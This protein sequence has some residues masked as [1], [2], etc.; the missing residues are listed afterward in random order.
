MGYCQRLTGVWGSALLGERG[1]VKLSMETTWAKFETHVIP[2]E[3]E[4]VKSPMV[5]DR[6]PQTDL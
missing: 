2:D 3:L 5:D 6:I 4:F 1:G